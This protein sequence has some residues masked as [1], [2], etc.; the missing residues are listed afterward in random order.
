[1]RHLPSWFPGTYYANLARKYRHIVR[2]LHEAPVT[3]IQT[4]MVCI[5]TDVQVNLLLRCV[6]AHGDAESSFVL[7]HLESMRLEG[8]QGRL[9][10]DDIKGTAA[11][12]HAA[13]T[14]TVDFPI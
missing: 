8:T 9:T 14:D 11:I 12:M 4:Q 1:M 2:K 10:L 7:T 13:G 5:I 3:K 6:Q